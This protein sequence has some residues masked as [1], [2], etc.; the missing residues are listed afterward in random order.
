MFKNLD[1]GDFTIRPF[2]VNKNFTSTNNDSG[3]GV[4]RISAYNGSTKNYVSSSDT[5]I[6]ITSG[7]TTTNYFAVPTWN[8]INT[9]FYRN[10]RKYKPTIRSV[11]EALFMEQY[12]FRL[13]GI[14]DYNNQTRELN[15][16]ASV[17]SV[18]RDLYGEEI[19]PGSIELSAT[20][21]SVT[22]DIRDDGD[23]NLY[24]NNHSASF[25]AFKSSS[26][27]RSQGVSSA[28]ATRGSGS[29]V[30]NI[31]YEQGLL[32]ITDTGSYLELGAQGNPYTLKHQ[33]THKIYEH[34]YVVHANPGEFNYSSNVSFTKDRKGMTKIHRPPE[35]DT[36]GDAD[37]S[38]TYRLFPPGDNPA[39]GTGSFPLSMSAAS[40]SANNVTHSEFYPYVTQIG[41]YDDDKELLAVGKVAHPIKLSKEITT[42]FVLR[43]D[44]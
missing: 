14:R 8:L 26:F 24:D 12:P 5:N 31:F 27:N 30:G 35:T 18:P 16:S 29:E 38:W 9:M 4:F 32:V 39:H 15:T 17:I 36:G 3:S 22:Y 41:L 37:R 33:A 7:S 25:A 13:F 1:T 23:G 21:N 20:I 10:F 42:T 2:K 43:F 6:T 40:H 28:E 34:E 19:K 11:D 44:T